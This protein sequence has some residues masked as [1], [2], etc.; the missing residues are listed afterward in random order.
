MG[1]WWWWWWCTGKK[2]VK[3]GREVRRAGYEAEWGLVHG[4]V[5]A[6]S[7][8]CH[9][10]AAAPHQVLSQSSRVLCPTGA[11]PPT[12]AAPAVLPGSFRLVGGRAGYLG[13]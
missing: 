13:L 9:R 6:G 4:W 11:G 7:G 1:W 3:A 8:S 5:W 12:C 10:T 2:A